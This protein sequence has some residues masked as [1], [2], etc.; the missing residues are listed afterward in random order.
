MEIHPCFFLVKFSMHINKIFFFGKFPFKHIKI[1][2]KE[3]EQT[4]RCITNTKN[5][6]FCN[7]IKHFIQ[8][9]HT[10]IKNYYQSK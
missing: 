10:C 9:T 4:N 8:Y 2:R 5:N 7:G 3:K 1:R 6:L